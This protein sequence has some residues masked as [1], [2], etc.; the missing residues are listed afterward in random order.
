MDP[1]PPPAPPPFTPSLLLSFPPSSPQLQLSATARG[2]RR[3][4]VFV[5]LP[6]FGVEEQEEFNPHCPRDC[7]GWRGGS[8]GCKMIQLASANPLLTPTPK[9]EPPPGLNSHPC[10][11]TVSH[12]KHRF[13]HVWLGLKH[14]IGWMITQITQIH[15]LWDTSAHSIC[16]SHTPTEE[17]YHS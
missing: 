2:P 17:K 11:T 5:V 16:L 7:R 8:S 3:N 4:S 15:H 10:T 6:F 14:K 12:Y 9:P 1:L 13:M